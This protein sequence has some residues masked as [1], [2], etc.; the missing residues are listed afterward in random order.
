[1]D[2]R[3]ILSIVGAELS[4]SELY[5]DYKLPLDYYL[6]NPDGREVAGRSQVVS[7]DVADAIEWI[8]PQIM[9]A[10]TQTN[11]VVVFDPTGQ[12]DEAQCAIESS[13]VYDVIMKENDGFIILHQFI[14]DALLHNNGIIK[15]YY[16]QLENVETTAF[17]GLT[18]E[19]VVMAVSPPNVT[20]L[21]HTINEDNSANI[22]LAVTALSS[23]VVME[24]IPP[25][26]FRYHKHHNSIN[27]DDCRFTAHVLTKTV[28]D[29]LQ[30]GYDPDVIAQL[31]TATNDMDMFR[32]T[33]QGETAASEYSEDPSLREVEIAE[34]YMRLDYNDDGIAEY[35]KVT[36]AGYDTPTHVLDLEPIDCSPWVSTT[37]IIM[38]HKFR[39]L[40]I[41]DRL[42]QIQEQKTS[43]WRNV[44]DNIYLQNN[45]RIGAVEGQVNMDDLLVS[46]PGGI[47]RLKRA[48]AIIPLATPAL[49]GDAYNMLQYL[50]SVRAGRVGVA[51][52]GEAAPQ[53]I[54]DQIGSEGVERMLSAK[55]ELV[56]LIVRVIAETGM[57]PLCTKIRNII[58]KHVDSVQ[59]YKFRGQW[60]KINPAEWK[61]R[62][63]ST[64]RVGTGTGNHAKQQ[65]ALQN[66]F[67]IQSQIF[68][69]PGQTLVTPAKVYAALDDL[70]KH[71]ELLG[72][73]KYFVDPDSQEGQQ[74]AQAAGEQ[75]QQEQQKQDQVQMA[76]L[77]SQMQIAQAELGKAQAQQENVKLKAQVEQLKG[78]LELAIADSESTH[79]DADRE[80][81]RYKIDTN[82][83]LKI[84]ELEVQSKQ[85]QELNAAQ[86]K[87]ALSDE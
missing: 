81:E 23:R 70:L 31:G 53:H 43:L 26:Q 51:P 57:K 11:E 79:K 52:E 8:M 73:T 68:Q 4:D 56:G 86:N 74:A 48:D 44:L 40:S 41:Y 5:T 24:S 9:K 27:L 14:K 29:L 32:F 76:M 6:G 46:R 16:E 85:Q 87:Q 20:V 82:A 18:T 83:A 72:A 71:S 35:C 39:G 28:S 2:D 47:V 38:S 21:E 7:T 25:E 13:Y 65:A 80:L 17:T 30:A 59:S 50:D 78:R 60:I 69:V 12:E 10:F 33:A 37:A 84:T 22:K 77:Q 67:A 61:N 45:Q 34:C 15:V 63:R 3:A 58:T 42:K 19:Q 64:V 54:G 49:S 55:E 62:T 75:Q 66:V 1:M 36:V